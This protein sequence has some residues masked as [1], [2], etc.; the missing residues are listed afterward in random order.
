MLEVFTHLAMEERVCGPVTVFQESVEAFALCL[1]A[2]CLGVD[3]SAY[4]LL[5]SSSIKE[6]VI[7]NVFR[8]LVANGAVY[9]QLGVQSE[10]TDFVANVVC[11]FAS[12]L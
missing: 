1:V 3:S 9:G 2:L 6:Y 10:T 8:T 12:C 5:S 4:L 7:N 11:G